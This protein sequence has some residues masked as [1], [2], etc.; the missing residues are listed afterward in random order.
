MG[1]AFFSNLSKNFNVLPSLLCGPMLYFPK[2]RN[3]ERRLRREYTKGF[4]LKHLFKE[5]TK[6]FILTKNLN[7]TENRQKLYIALIKEAALK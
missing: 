6:F 4:L 1:F 2:T 7:H 5:A 3:N